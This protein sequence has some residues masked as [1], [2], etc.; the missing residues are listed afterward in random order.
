MKTYNTIVLSKR[1]VL[2]YY[3]PPYTYVNIKYILINKVK[4]KLK[5]NNIVWFISYNFKI[6]L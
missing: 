2:H 3:N 1:V 4:R 6:N 5:R